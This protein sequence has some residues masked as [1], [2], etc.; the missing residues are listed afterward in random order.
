M[1]QGRGIEVFGLMSPEEAG[2]LNPV[3]PDKLSDVDIIQLHNIIK[4]SPNI[5]K[6]YITKD[7]GWYTS[8]FLYEGGFEEFTEYEGKYFARMDTRK[9]QAFDTEKREMVNKKFNIPIANFEIVKEISN[10]EI[11]ELFKKIKK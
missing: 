5:K 10:V 8:K 4:G 6:L 11:A 1:A 7:G 3:N 9:K 2:V